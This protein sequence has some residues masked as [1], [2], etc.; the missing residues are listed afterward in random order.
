MV[1]FSAASAASGSKMELSISFSSSPSHRFRIFDKGRAGNGRGGRGGDEDREMHLTFV[2]TK[3]VW[4]SL[5]GS[6]PLLNSTRLSLP[7]IRHF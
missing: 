1:D 2:V 3:V 6:L 4:R 7:I 5:G